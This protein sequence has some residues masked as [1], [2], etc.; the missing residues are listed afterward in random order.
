M[1]ERRDDDRLDEAVR[2]V[3]TTKF[4]AI[5]SGAKM[6]DALEVL[7]QRKISELPVVDSDSRPIGLIDITD[8]IE[9]VSSRAKSS[10]LEL[11]LNMQDR[12]DV[13]RDLPTTIRLFT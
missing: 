2:K 10:P 6:Q 3:M 13:H 11:S 7:A 9:L 1:L 12:A 5:S 4:T 8:V